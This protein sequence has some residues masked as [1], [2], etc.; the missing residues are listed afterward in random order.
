M[1]DAKETGPYATSHQEEILRG[2]EKTQQ[3]AK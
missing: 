3:L 1:A 2:W